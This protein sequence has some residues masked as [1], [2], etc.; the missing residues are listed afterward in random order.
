[1]HAYA[2]HS[3]VD[4]LCESSGCMLYMQLV[5]DHV[6]LGCDPVHA[7]HVSGLLLSR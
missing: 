3:F 1:M 7:F 6:G 2:M 5:V 4:Y